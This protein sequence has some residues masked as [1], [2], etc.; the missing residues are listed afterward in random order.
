[1]N[2]AIVVEEGNGEEFA[3]LAAS[4]RLR[5]FHFALASLRNRDDAEDITQDC[6]LRAHRGWKRFRGECS[7]QTWLIGIAGNLIRDARRRP[8]DRFRNGLLRSSSVHLVGSIPDPSSSPEQRLLAK[9]KVKVVRKSMVENLSPNQRRV[10]FLRFMKEMSFVEIET[11]TGISSTTVRVHLSRAARSV[12][13]E[14]R[15][16]ER[17]IQ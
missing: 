16:F 10:F 3:E 13:S 15:Q 14:L 6:L 4:H 1:M 17:A 8:R 12:R 2:Q 5:V 9:Q 7:P 11:M